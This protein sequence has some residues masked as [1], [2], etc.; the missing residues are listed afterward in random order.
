MKKTPKKISK[1]KKIVKFKETIDVRPFLM[2]QRAKKVSRTDSLE[3][4]V[5][6]DSE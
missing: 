3:E 5:N 4:D 6:F 1:T 2:D